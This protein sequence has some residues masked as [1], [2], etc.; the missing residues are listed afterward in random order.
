MERPNTDW[1]KVFAQHRPDNRLRPRMYT[2]LLKR[3]D[4]HAQVIKQW[5]RDLSRHLIKQDNQIANRHMKRE[6]TSHTDRE[7]Q[8]ETA[9]LLQREEAGALAA[10]RR[11]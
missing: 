1:E 3:S 9:R 4:K 10:Q 2:E 5:A 7:T 6:D 8:V 11:P